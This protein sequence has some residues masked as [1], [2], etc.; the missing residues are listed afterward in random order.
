[1]ANV[2]RVD[3]VTSD[4]FLVKVFFANDAGI[5]TA[6]V[7]LDDGTNKVVPHNLACKML[8]LAPTFN[9]NLFV[10]ILG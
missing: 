8:A 3:N 5:T 2:N 4:G 7:R 10:E 9:R 1:M 6:L